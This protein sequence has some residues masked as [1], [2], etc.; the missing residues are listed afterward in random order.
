MRYLIVLLMLSSFNVYAQA[1]TETGGTL[2]V[3]VPD[4]GIYLP[5]RLD[6]DNQEL[7]SQS[8][9]STAVS[10]ETSFHIPQDTYIRFYDPYTDNTSCQMFYTPSGTKVVISGCA[11][12][13]YTV[14]ATVLHLYPAALD[15]CN[16]GNL[17]RIRHQTSDNRHYVCD[18]SRWRLLAHA[19]PASVTLDYGSIPSLSCSSMT[20]T[21]TGAASGD[22]V[23]CSPTT[24]LGGGLT[25]TCRMSNTD[26]VEV[27]VCNVSAASIDPV[28]TV[29]NV[30]VIR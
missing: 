3:D 25:W 16:S 1:I 2:S 9:R 17:G 14:Q 27:R 22:T 18:G 8:Y 15:T 23:V 5:T 7:E 28:S 24:D 12:E 11:F 13:T 20:G 29:F 26:E 6:H 19:V 30:K 21:I 10:T 4:A